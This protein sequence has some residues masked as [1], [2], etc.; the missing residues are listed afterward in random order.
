MNQKQIS[1]FVGRITQIE[2]EKI[3][4]MKV[5]PTISR[6]ETRS[7]IVSFSTSRIDDSAVIEQMLND[8][9]LHALSPFQIVEADSYTLSSV[10]KKAQLKVFE[11]TQ[12]GLENSAKQDLSIFLKTI[13]TIH[14][15][16]TRLRDVAHFGR[17]EKELTKMLAQFVKFNP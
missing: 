8:D 3:S 11:R 12:K 2:N 1:Y 9:T 13:E 17:D 6:H 14:A 10:V 15:E 7:G 16:A 5:P 4:G